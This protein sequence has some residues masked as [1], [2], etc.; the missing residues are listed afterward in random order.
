MFSDSQ[1]KKLVGKKWRIIL[2]VTKLFADKIL[3]RIFFFK[4]GKYLQQ[5]STLW[6]K[7]KFPLSFLYFF[8]LYSSFTLDLLT[9]SKRFILASRICL[10]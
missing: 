8:V 6:K 1:A 2:Q 4:E 5:P 9:T 7:N 3:C 10:T